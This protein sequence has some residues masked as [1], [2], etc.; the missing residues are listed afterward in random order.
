MD[1]QKMIIK[2][3]MG[4][5]GMEM[6]LVM[7]DSMLW[8]RGLGSVLTVC[9]LGTLPGTVQTPPNKRAKERELRA[10]DTR[11]ADILLDMAVADITLEK[12]AN[13][14]AAPRVAERPL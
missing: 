14:L 13:K 4:M 10:R 5:A 3:R 2:L 6:K 1:N 8:G 11:E 7:E 12:D 9:S